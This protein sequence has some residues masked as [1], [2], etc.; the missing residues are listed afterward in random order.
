MSTILDD[1][2]EL[3]TDHLPAAHRS[4]RN[5]M[6]LA[7]A[8]RSIHRPADRDDA[9]AARRRLAYDDLLL[10]QL[11]V[12]MKRHHR[13]SVLRAPALRHDETIAARIED[14]FPF[15]L[16]D[17]QRAVID[18][19]VA[20]VIGDHPMNRLVQGD[21]GAGKTV[22][23][24]YVMLMA[25]ASGHQAALMAPTELLAEQHHA[26]ITSM[27]DQSDV[28]IDLLTG[29]LRASERR[30]LLERLERGAID[31][32]IGTHAI[33]TESVTFNSP[34]V[35]VIDEQHR[36]GVRQRSR[37]HGKS[38][39]ETDMPH[40]LV[41]TAT[42][43][44]RTLS[45]TLFGDLDISTIRHLP[46]GRQ[47]VQTRHVG[48]E[49]AD[50]VYRWV[51]ERIEGGDQA[52]IVV[53]AVEG[54]DADLRSVHEQLERLRGGALHG[55]TVEGMHGRLARTERDRIMQRFRSGEIDALVAT[56]VIEVG[57]DV[58]N[59]TMM[60][61]E[62]ADR[63]G[64]A[65][66]HQLR[67]RVGR[68]TQASVCILIAE[69]TTAEGHARLEAIVA[70]TDGFQIAERDL[71]IRG[72][73]ELFGARQSGLAPFLAADLTKDLDLLQLA[74]RDA[75]EWIRRNPALDGEDALLRRR[76]L[77]AHGN[78]LGLGDVG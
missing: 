5:L 54:S 19:I 70:S 74:R 63:F 39:G 60:V 6:S 12:M 26:A 47:P 30:D 57:V 62:H 37:L 22:V 69:P 16:T 43:I 17:D 2:V 58:P 59:A 35:M 77:K 48:P 27:L 55:R 64:L 73:G 42:P 9:A 14:R 76:L 11:G 65:Q 36:F 78:A 41:M 52:F 4:E 53:P 46:P 32:L 75:A 10:L 45:L 23:A 34:A 25:V 1:A 67:G 61:I 71:Q 7:N 56:T 20:D 68:G 31:L 38:G 33:T 24:L 40:V 72:P 3:L 29:S 28:S 51:D 15:P 50:E 8:Y 18:E 49:R 21:V 66:L 13:R 44:P